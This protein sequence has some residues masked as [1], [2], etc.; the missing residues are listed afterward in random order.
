MSQLFAQLCAILGTQ[1]T[2]GG[3]LAPLPGVTDV[4][5]TGLPFLLNYVSPGLGIVATLSL[6]ET[7]GNVKVL[8]SPKMSVLNNGKDLY[9]ISKPQKNCINH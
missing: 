5:R 4:A 8:S 3:A 6:L 7:F 9:Y 1:P 2:G